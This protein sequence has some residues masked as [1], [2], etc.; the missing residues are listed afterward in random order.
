[1]KFTAIAANARKPCAL[2]KENGKRRIG[3]VIELA[4][5]R[6]LGTNR[7]CVAGRITAG[8]CGGNRPKL[9]GFT[10]IIGQWPR[11]PDHQQSNQLDPDA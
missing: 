5:G 2:Y 4:E 3:V 10:E 7:L 9:D 11:H 8:G 1:M 6:A